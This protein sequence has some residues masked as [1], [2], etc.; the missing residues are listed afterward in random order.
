M[1]LNTCTTVDMPDKMVRNRI[2]N[3]I[4]I[5]IMSLKSGVLTDGSQ[6]ILCKI[7]LIRQKFKNQGQT[8]GN[9]RNKN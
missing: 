9:T 4:F 5:N 1:F 3:I 8:A 2:P 7:D 6:Y